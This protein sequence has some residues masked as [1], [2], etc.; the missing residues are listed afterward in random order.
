MK[1]A[2]LLLLCV[3]CFGQTSSTSPGLT[4]A[5]LSKAAKTYLRD[6]AEF[7][8]KMHLSMTAT[9]AD[10]RIVKHDTAEGQLDFHGYNPRDDRANASIRVTTKGMFHSPKGMLPAAWNAFVA[11]TVPADALLKD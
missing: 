3:Y 11:S 8:L 7:P 9:N 10:G 6:S 4:F 1:L 2:A 5:E